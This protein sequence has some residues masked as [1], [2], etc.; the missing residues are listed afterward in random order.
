[1]KIGFIT[2]EFPPK[3]GG[4]GSHC[5]N[6]ANK[7]AERGHLIHLITRKIHGSLPKLHDNIHIHLVNYLPIP[8][9]FTKSVGENCINYLIKKQIDVDLVHLQYQMISVSK[10]LFKKIKHPIVSTFHGSWLGERKSL[11]YSQFKDMNINDFA[12][13]YISKYF[14]IYEEIGFRNSHER[15]TISNASASELSSY[16]DDISL[17]DFRIIPNGVDTETFYPRISQRK[18]NEIR[19]LFVG[20]FAARKGIYDL[21]KAFKIITQKRDDVKLYLVG[22]GKLDTDI[23]NV[24][25]LSNLSFDKLVETYSNSDIFVLPSYYEGQG[26]VLL[27][28]M[29][30]GLPCIATNVGGAP[31]TVIDGENGKIIEPKDHELLAKS[32]LKLIEDEGLRRKYGE[33]GRKIALEKYDWKLIAK[34]TENVYKTLLDK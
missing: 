23:K 28:A 9:F 2:G 25:I 12:V 7:L 10:S 27:E 21:L 3:W 34:K 22:R 13:R 6:L 26:I 14:Q 8:V 30:S 20:R 11:E 4:I 32:L 16:S 19:L 24:K 5:F 17:K 31:E 33:E 15:I 1:M 18:D 29:S